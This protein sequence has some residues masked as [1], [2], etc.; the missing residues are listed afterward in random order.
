MPSDLIY[1]RASGA[2][3]ARFAILGNRS[4]RGVMPPASIA[5]DNGLPHDY[6]V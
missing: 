5:G 6:R 3:N 1:F 2:L 4:P